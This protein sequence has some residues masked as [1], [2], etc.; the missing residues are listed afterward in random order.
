M[1]VRVGTK[2]QVVIEK[3]IRDALGIEPGALAVQRLVGDHVEIRFLP[4][5]HERSLRGRLREMA[6][7]RV[8]RTRWH[9]VVEEAWQEAALREE[10]DDGGE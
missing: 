3:E 5:E 2:G 7:R 4:A 6:K 1:P 8:P 10:G 9:S